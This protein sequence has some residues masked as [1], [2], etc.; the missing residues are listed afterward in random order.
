M[1]EQLTSNVLILISLSCS[2]YIPPLLLN[3][4][5]S[6]VPTYMDKLGIY[7]GGTAKREQHRRLHLERPTY[8]YIW[9]H[10]VHLVTIRS[11][12]GHKAVT[13]HT[14][15]GLLALKNLSDFKRLSD[16][17]LPAIPPEGALLASHGLGTTP[18]VGSPNIAW[19]NS[20][21]W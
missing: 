19:N 3:F 10:L 9:S 11:H 2:L 7:G 16:V 17:P 5:C 14:G 4:S 21:T 1:R 12:S 13:G 15:S 8:W 20:T 6:L 18:T